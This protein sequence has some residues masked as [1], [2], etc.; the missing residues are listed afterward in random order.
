M[1]A[2]VIHSNILNNIIHSCS[3]EMKC[4]TYVNIQCNHFWMRILLKIDAIGITLSNRNVM[5]RYRYV[6]PFLLSWRLYW[7]RMLIVS[8][9]SAFS[10]ERTTI[11]SNIICKHIWKVSIQQYNV[12]NKNANNSISTEI[13]LELRTWSQSYIKFEIPKNNMHV[14]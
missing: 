8:D 13:E 10:T 2:T 3:N 9:G 5:I 12:S 1:N 14:L 7:N 4:Q 6:L 11:C